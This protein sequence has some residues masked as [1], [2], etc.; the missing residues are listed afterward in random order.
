MFGSQQT[1]TTGDDRYT[2]PWIFDELGITFDIDVCTPP[3]GVPWIHS[4]YRY[5]VEDDGLAQ[6][7][8]GTVWCNPPYSNPLPWILKMIEHGDG[9]FLGPMSAGAK[10]CSLAFDTCTSFAPLIHIKFAHSDG[11]Y[12]TIPVAV[13][14]FAYGDRADAALVKSAR[15][16]A[17]RKVIG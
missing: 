4:L 6:E 16:T 1:Q 13:G 5:T 11:A 2:P 17:M 10:W 15:F 8:F 14:L 3:G 9:L 12:R 7:W